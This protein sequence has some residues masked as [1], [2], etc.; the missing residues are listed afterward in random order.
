VPR[1]RKFSDEERARSLA[2]RRLNA[3]RKKQQG[4]L[5][6]PV[7]EA[8]YDPPVH[9]VS[10]ATVVMNIAVDRPP[11]LEHGEPEPVCWRCGGVATMVIRFPEVAIPELY[12]CPLPQCRV[13]PPNIKAVAP[14]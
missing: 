5:A 2:T 6:K 9:P 8:V 13:T 4:E 12:A 10:T 7:P 3:L 11:T 14:L 1:G